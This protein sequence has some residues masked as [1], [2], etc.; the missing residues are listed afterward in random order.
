[1]E[2]E[3]D[4]R[5]TGNGGGRKEEGLQDEEEQ[6]DSQEDQDTG[7]YPTS[8]SG[9][10]A[11]AVLVTAVTDCLISYGLS[12]WSQKNRAEDQELRDR[13]YHLRP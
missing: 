6:E 11:A 8:P 3:R 7:Q 10:I 9:E 1:M 2:G 12:S 4:G 13:A 5:R